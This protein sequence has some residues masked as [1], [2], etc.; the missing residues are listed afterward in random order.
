MFILTKI[1]NST[2]ELLTDS[3]NGLFFTSAKKPI[4]NLIEKLRYYFFARIFYPDTPV[5]YSPKV[6]I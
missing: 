1:G 3:N 5:F 6:L 2:L 4:S